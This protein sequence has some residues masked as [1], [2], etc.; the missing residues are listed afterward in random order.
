MIR[1][2]ISNEH[3]IDTIFILAL[4][5]LF[6]MTSFLVVAIGAKQYQSI[7][8]NMTANYETRTITAYLQEKI[9]QSDC[10]DVLTICTIGNSDALKLTQKIQEQSYDTYIYA[11]DGYLWEITVSSLT[12]VAPGNGQKIIETGHWEIEEFPGNLFC[13][14]ITD[15]AGDTY[16]LYVSLNSK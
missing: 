4:L 10:S 12:A 5:V 13:F 15:T 9:N 3:R 8:D 6:A 7:A 2:K 1:L 14:H 16:P 11:Y